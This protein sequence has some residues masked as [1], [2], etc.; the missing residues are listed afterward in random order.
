[1][2]QEFYES[3]DI[4]KTIQLTNLSDLNSKTFMF[5]INRHTTLREIRKICEYK[6]K[7]HF[8]TFRMFTQEGVEIFLE[9]L[10]YLRDKQKLYIG[11][12][13]DANVIYSEYQIIRELGKG[14]FGQVLLGQHRETEQKVAIKIV[15]AKNRNADD[16][17]MVFREA[18]LLKSL[19]H[20]NIVKIFNCL[21]LRNMSVIFVMEYL[22]GGELLKYV[23]EKGS[24]NEDEARFYF[25]QLCDAISYCHN[26]RL[27]HRD[28]KLENILFQ[29]QDK[30]VVKI[31]DFGI[32]GMALQTNN[33]KLN[34]GT[35]RYMAPETLNKTYNKIGPS[36][37]VWALGVILFV[38][39]FGHM[40]F[41][42]ETPNEIIQAIFHAQYKFPKSDMMDAIDLISR[43]FIVDPIKRIKLYDI[44]SHDW[45][46]VGQI[47]KS[48]Y[49]PEKKAKLGQITSF[50]LPLIEERPLKTINSIRLKKQPI[51][52]SPTIRRKI[53]SLHHPG[54]KRA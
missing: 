46:R 35:L 29:G 40:P 41:D 20:K 9:D 27:I 23:E 12:D 38:M 50:K 14:G 26:K 10:Y 34:V 1:M 30:K 5:N 51:S 2:Y 22:E 6:W 32:A 43:I 18:Y 17:E 4:Q 21:P 33:D 52:T 13:F 54:I 42:G 3:L 47:S 25:A 16:I 31:V 19:D 15:N 37:D 28:L 45:M 8:R 49:H 7:K 24:L 11:E 44:Q 36:I 53:T 48:N 39:L